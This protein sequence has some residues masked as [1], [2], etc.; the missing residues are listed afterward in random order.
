MCMNC[1]WPKLKW[2][3]SVIYVYNRSEDTFAV[4]TDGDFKTNAIVTERVSE[5]KQ[6]ERGGLR[7]KLDSKTYVSKF[8]TLL[9]LLHYAFN[10]VREFVSL[11][12]Y[13]RTPVESA[14]RST[15]YYALRSGKLS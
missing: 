3:L 11:Q 10:R 9:H 13:V 15:A 5:V 14:S 12:L 8:V 6:V 4:V 2:S 1:Q 7:S